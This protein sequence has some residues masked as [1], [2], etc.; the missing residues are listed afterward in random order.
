MGGEIVVSCIDIVA[1]IA[2]M[3]TKAV[4]VSKHQFWS[5]GWP[6]F[7]LCRQCQTKCLC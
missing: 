1:M 4:S 6:G 3:L 2:D 7:A 5:W